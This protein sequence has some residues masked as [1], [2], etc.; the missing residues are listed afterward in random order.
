MS[1]GRVGPVLGRVPPELMLELDEA[2][3][4]HLQL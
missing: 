4:T 1:V 2:L 3:R